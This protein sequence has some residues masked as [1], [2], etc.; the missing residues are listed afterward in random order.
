MTYC[1]AYDKIDLYLKKQS[2]AVFVNDGPFS[3]DGNA[4]EG[5]SLV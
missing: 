2:G 5:V 4:S 1:G 3:L